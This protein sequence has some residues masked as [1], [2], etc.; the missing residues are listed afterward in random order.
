ML[1]AEGKQISGLAIFVSRKLRDYLQRI[2]KD[3][4]MVLCTGLR[5]TPIS[6]EEQKKR[7][8]KGHGALL[9]NGK[10]KRPKHAPAHT[11]VYACICMYTTSG[12]INLRQGS[13]KYPHEIKIEIK[14]RPK[15]NFFQEG[16]PEQS[17][18]ATS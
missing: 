17:E 10:S 11:V 4:F 15:D 6:C 12:H 3:K 1:H 18:T 7:E 2:D 5:V 14:K 8:E 16:D 9:F 13:S